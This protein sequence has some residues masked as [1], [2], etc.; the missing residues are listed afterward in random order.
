[1]L[2]VPTKCHSLS[3]RVRR[4]YVASRCPEVNLRSTEN[5]PS[6]SRLIHPD[7]QDLVRHLSR[8][9]RL[10]HRATYLERYDEEPSPVSYAS[11]YQKTR[12][13]VCDVRGRRNRQ[14]ALSASP[15]NT[16]PFAAAGRAVTKTAKPVTTATIRS[17]RIRSPRP[18]APDFSVLREDSPGSRPVP[19]LGGPGRSRTAAPARSPLSDPFQAGTTSRTCRSGREPNI[20]VPHDLGRVGFGYYGINRYG[21]D[22]YQ[23]GS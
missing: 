16:S 10:M 9:S 18:L 23:P 14:E 5:S 6:S 7:C 1:M 22:W 2:A 4:R 3:F 15:A 21:L 8:P 19:A 17:L 12:R 13:Y 20:C 11:T